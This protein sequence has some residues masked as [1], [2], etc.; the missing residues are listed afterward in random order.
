V[1]REIA[2]PVAALAAEARPVGAHLME[3]SGN[4]D[5]ANFGLISTARWHGVPVLSLLD[6]IQPLAGP[7]RARVTGVDDEDTPSRSS[8]PG[9]S[10]IFSRHDLE[11]T[12]AFLATQMNGA[13]LTPDHGFPVRLVVPGWYGCSCIKWVSRIDLVADDEKATGQMQEFA[14]R[15][16]QNG[17]PTLA[18]DY[19]APAIDLA[20]MPIRVEQWRVAG[21]DKPVYRVVGVR[22][23]GQGQAQRCGLTIRFRASEPFVPVAQ[24]DTSPADGTSWSLWSHLWR[25]DA[26]GRYQIVLGTSDPAIRTRRLDLRYYTRECEIYG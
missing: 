17:V 10:W 23:G 18:R 15:T 21:A 8:V 25:P 26:P 9:A 16:H 2:V 6:R 5:P 20:A 7:W 14:G 13:P 12:R 24:C 3:C 19:E 1:H 4:T 11:R 22:W